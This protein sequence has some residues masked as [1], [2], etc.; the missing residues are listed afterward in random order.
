MISG[1]KQCGF[2]H[3]CYC[4]AIPKIACD[5]HVTLLTHEN[6]LSRPT[7][8]GHLVKRILT[9]CE[10]ETWQRK[11]SVKALK[12]TKPPVLLFPSDQSRSIS[13]LSIEEAAS[14]QFII[15]DATWQEAHKMLNRTPE[16][17]QLP[18]VMI[19]G[20]QNTSYSLRRNQQKGNLCTYEVVA[21]LVQQISGSKQAEEMMDFFKDY[22]HRFQAERSGHQYKNSA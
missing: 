9:N 5:L 4:Q 11:Q 3:N 22:L 2:I 21:Q 10:I 1:C 7:N 17:N 6:E 12:T 13:E 19:E 15:L 20:A 8:T 18:K 16:L 14:T